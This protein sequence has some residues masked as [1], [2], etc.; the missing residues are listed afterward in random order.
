[1]NNKHSGDSAMSNAQLTLQDALEV[2]RSP[3]ML[4]ATSLVRDL[5]G[6]A[7]KEGFLF[8]EPFSS[9]CFR[10]D[11]MLETMSDRLTYEYNG[12]FLQQP[13]LTIVTGHD[14]DENFD[15]RE[16]AVVYNGRVSE[17]SFK[18]GAK[19]DRKVYYFS[20]YVLADL[21][22]KKDGKKVPFAQLPTD[23]IARMEQGINEV[24]A[25]K[26]CYAWFRTNSGYRFV[27][28]AN[29]VQVFWEGVSKVQADDYI[30][31]VN[32]KVH[33]MAVDAF[34]DA[35]LAPLLAYFPQGNG[36]DCKFDA[37]GN[38]ATNSVG[39]SRL[40]KVVRSTADLRSTEVH[41]NDNWNFVANIHSY[42]QKVQSQAAP[43]N[44]RPAVATKLAKTTWIETDT[45]S[46]EY[47]DH[48]YNTA[49]DCKLVA[50]LVGQGVRPEYESWRG[51]IDQ[52]GKLA[53]QYN[54]DRFKDLAIEVSSS[55][56]SDGKE[57]EF[58]TNNYS[59]STSRK[60]Y[61]AIHMSTFLSGWHKDLP[62]DV[63]SYLSCNNKY[64]DLVRSLSGVWHY[65]ATI[66]CGNATGKHPFT[67]NVWEAPKVSRVTKSDDEEKARTLNLAI[68][69][70]ILLSDTLLQ[71]IM[72]F[73]VMSNEVCIHPKFADI[74]DNDGATSFKRNIWA[75][76]WMNEGDFCALT[77]YL[78]RN[79]SL[80]NNTSK[81]SVINFILNP[82]RGCARTKF[83]MYHVNKVVE[84]LRG[85]HSHYKQN[86]GIQILGTDRYLE[87]WLPVVLGIDPTLND[88]T[89]AAYLEYGAK[90]ASLI[91]SLVARAM[92]FN[93][94]EKL[95]SLFIFL[96]NA[97]GTGKTELPKAILSALFGVGV[98]EAK[99]NQVF[100]SLCYVV[101]S[102]VAED[103]KEYIINSLSKLIVLQDEMSKNNLK[104]EGAKKRDISRTSDTYTPKYSNSAITVNRTYIQMAT[105]NHRHIVNDL[106]GGNR[107]N[108]IVDLDRQDSEGFYVCQLL[109]RGDLTSKVRRPVDSKGNNGFINH[110]STDAQLLISLAIGEA[111]SRVCLGEDI[112][113]EVITSKGNVWAKSDRL[114]SYPQMNAIGLIDEDLPMV[115]AE[116]FDMHSD[117]IEVVRERMDEYQLHGGDES[118]DNLLWTYVYGSDYSC[119]GEK[120]G[121]FK[122]DDIQTWFN[123]VKKVKLQNQKFSA[124][125]E[126]FNSQNMAVDG[127]SVRIDRV[128]KGQLRGYQFIVDG[129]A[130]EYNPMYHLDRINTVAFPAAGSALRQR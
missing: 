104:E 74:L 28:R 54:D 101:D 87:N 70:R 25:T 2:V 40:P 42:I 97:G 121:F 66:S 34:V 13:G 58:L 29:P 32:N 124:W 61:G 122:L 103:N 117:D 127:S 72:Y 69:E 7:A 50:Y 63:L 111:F 99:A 5:Q 53:L 89:K 120:T 80:K 115:K 59:R 6:A 76:K 52:Y 31:L 130:V 19:T 112:P 33:K 84:A 1:M 92:A 67:G 16:L 77:S 47:V 68:G 22:I 102:S 18:G 12:D 14:D 24:Y 86:K 83:N 98:H 48:L 45:T 4:P 8:T 119:L 123:D 26:N 20:L 118:I 15:L 37:S 85:R 49:K 125:V 128:R 114:R 107:R 57:E 65:Y 71:Q 56:G 100:S 10:R 113:A 106:T 126:S 36:W 96:G 109:S 91:K 64:S 93:N 27:I 62:D 94:P 105:S 38:S 90:G 60:D 39:L 110:S 88:D 46:Q 21:D 79:H 41:I 82:I 11:I 43:S 73:D 108:L 35:E 81:E 78:I 95:E 129:K 9:A 23:V 30:P 3:L 44:V 75:Y 55:L 51:L 116:R 17:A